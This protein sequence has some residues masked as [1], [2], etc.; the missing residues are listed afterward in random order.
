MY[1][2]SSSHRGSLRVL[3][4]LPFPSL[5]PW[6]LPVMRPLTFP[7]PPPL[8]RSPKPDYGSVHSPCQV[9]PSCSPPAPSLSVHNWDVITGHQIWGSLSNSTVLQVQPQKPHPSSRSWDTTF[10]YNTFRFCVL[11]LVLD[12]VNSLNMGTL[13]VTSTWIPHL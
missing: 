11:S 12:T 6:F 5:S 1:L 7:I 9:T 2:H 10:L 8:I 13:P 4:L 3:P